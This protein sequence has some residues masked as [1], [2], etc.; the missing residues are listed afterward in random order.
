MVCTSLKMIIM[1]ALSYGYL[2]IQFWPQFKFIN[3]ILQP[4]GMSAYRNLNH[5][6]WDFLKCAFFMT[7]CCLLSG[8]CFCLRLQQPSGK[9]LTWARQIILFNFLLAIFFTQVHVTCKEKVCWDMTP[10][11]LV[12]FTLQLKHWPLASH[13]IIGVFRL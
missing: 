7:S 3:Y 9:D 12:S 1:N 4:V 8:L 10:C 5:S 2:P 13:Y 11:W 6:K